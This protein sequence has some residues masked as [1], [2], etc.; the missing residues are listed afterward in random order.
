MYLYIYI[1][2][3]YVCI[4]AYI[5]ANAPIRFYTSPRANVRLMLML[6]LMPSVAS[7]AIYSS[8]TQ[9]IHNAM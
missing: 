5:Y 2:N 9:P 3:T 8:I 6:E 7:L 4:H 1:I